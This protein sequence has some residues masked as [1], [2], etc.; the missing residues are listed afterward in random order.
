MYMSIKKYGK[1]YQKS[2]MR[3]QKEFIHKYPRGNCGLIED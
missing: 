3:R 2:H 1:K